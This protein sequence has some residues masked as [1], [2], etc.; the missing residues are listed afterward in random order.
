MTAKNPVGFKSLELVLIAELMNPLA[1]PELLGLPEVVAVNALQT[2]LFKMEV[3]VA[4]GFTV[5]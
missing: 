4:M 3:D 2:L 5:R 1:N